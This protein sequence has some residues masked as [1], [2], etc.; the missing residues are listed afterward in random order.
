MLINISLLILIVVVKFS[1][2][3]RQGWHR[4]ETGLDWTGPDWTDGT[5]PIASVSETDETGLETSKPLGGLAI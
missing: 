3:S 4:S 5:G 2:N 1:Y